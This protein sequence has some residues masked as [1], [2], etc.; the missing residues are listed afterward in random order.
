MPTAPPVYRCG[1]SMIDVGQH[2]R[3][4]V[5]VCP[6]HGQETA[7]YEHPAVPFRGRARLELIVQAESR[8]QVQ[9]WLDTLVENLLREEIVAGLDCSGPR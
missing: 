5:L 9:R 4:G 7:P 1:C 3:E 2:F 6:V 8:E